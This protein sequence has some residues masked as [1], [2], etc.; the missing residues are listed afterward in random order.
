MSLANLQNTIERVGVSVPYGRS[1]PVFE[2]P[3][4]ITPM[5]EKEIPTK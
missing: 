2:N 5:V 3:M 4:M 1:Y